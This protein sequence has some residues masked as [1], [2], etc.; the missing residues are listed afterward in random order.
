MMNKQL[1]KQLIERFPSFFVDMYKSP[2]ETCLAFGCDCGNGWAKLIWD[3]CEEIEQYLKTHELG[4]N[5]KFEQIKQKFGGL[6][7]YS[8]GDQTICDILDRAEDKSFHICEDCGKPGKPNT[9]GWITTLC[10]ECRDEE[11][12]K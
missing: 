2:M 12:K 10:D 1:E 8:N 4:Y 3:T 5:F 11:N 7:I 6:R 9:D